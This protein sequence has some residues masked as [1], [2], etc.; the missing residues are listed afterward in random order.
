MPPESPV[1]G[2]SC[3]E[4]W[5][6]ITATRGRSRGEVDRGSVMW[7]FDGRRGS[8]SHRLLQPTPNAFP[9]PAANIRGG[10]CAGPDANDPP[11][12]ADRSQV[13]A[14]RLGSAD[15]LGSCL[16]GL[17]VGVHGLADARG[18][19]LHLTLRLAG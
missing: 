15:L 1:P 11:R 2:W 10:E 3:G 16:H 14:V 19:R 8:T 6:L 18:R 12:G 5:K 13:T 7:S 9:F 4:V 17:G